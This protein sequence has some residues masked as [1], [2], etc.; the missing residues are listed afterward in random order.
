MYLMTCTQPDLAYPL[1]LL[2]C[3]VAPGRNRKGY[4]F[5]LGS[6]SVP[7]RSTH[8]FVSSSQRGQLRLA[9]VATRANT[10]DIFTKAHSLGDHQRFSTVLG[11]LA[12]LFMTRLV[13]TCSPPLCLRG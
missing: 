2:A 11:L 10:A 4:T 13:T 12:L 9:Y 6:A 5:S 1:S 3:Y 7:W 8:S